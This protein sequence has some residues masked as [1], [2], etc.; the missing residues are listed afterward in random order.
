MPILLTIVVAIANAVIAS[1]VSTPLSPYDWPILLPHS[2]VR[3][4]E[5]PPHPWSAGHRGVDLAA[6]PGTVVTAAGPG[7]VVFSGVVAGRGVIT[8]RHPDGRRT[9]YEPLDARLPRS[10]PVAAGT[11]IGRLSE[12][13]SHC[14]PR[15]CLHWGYSSERTSIEI[16]SRCWPVPRSSCCR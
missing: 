15:S 7:I 5:A 9:T 1:S 16:R 4:F 3:P 6:T 10:S 12:T 14:A 2:V 8:V 13:G 11:P